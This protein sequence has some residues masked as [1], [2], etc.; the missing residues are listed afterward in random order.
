MW[1]RETRRAQRCDPTK[2]A[3]PVTTT[4]SFRSSFLSW[5]AASVA[6]SPMSL[7]SFTCQSRGDPVAMKA[8]RSPPFRRRKESFLCCAAHRH[9]LPL[10][11]KDRRAF[12]RTRMSWASYVETIHKMT[13]FAHRGKDEEWMRKHLEQETGS[14]IGQFGMSARAAVDQAGNPPGPRSTGLTNPCPASR[15]MVSRSSL[16]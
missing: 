6:V 1:P 3:P 16:T 2:P 12:R 8:F 9:E 10:R 5:P 11:S 13:Q 15:S 7:I 4:V 14:A